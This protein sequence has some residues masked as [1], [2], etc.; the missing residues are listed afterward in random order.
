MT[1]HSNKLIKIIA[2]QQCLSQENPLTLEAAFI[3]L[4]VKLYLDSP[5]EYLPLKRFNRASGGPLSGEKY[6]P[7]RIPMA[8]GL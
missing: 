2:L 7:E 3:A 6:F 5:S 4:L 1:L 8:R